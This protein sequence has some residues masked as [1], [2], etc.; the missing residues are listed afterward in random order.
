MSIPNTLNSTYNQVTRA[1]VLAAGGV[2]VTAKKRTDEGH[3]IKVTQATH[4]VLKLAE[5]G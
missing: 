1:N 5:I 3:G 4:F 2:L